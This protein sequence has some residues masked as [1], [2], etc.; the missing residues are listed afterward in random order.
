MTRLDWILLGFV[1][2]TAL[3]G[4]RS[5]LVATL[6]SLA[7]LVAGAVFGARVAPGL[8]SVD[9]RFAA[10]VALGGGVAGAV[11]LRALASLAGSFVRGGLRLV[12]PL[13]ALDSAG[14]AALGALWG[15]AL[16]W[17]AGAVAL[18]LPTQGKVRREVKTSQ[19]IQRL[20]ELAPPREVLDV[21]PRLS[22]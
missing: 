1:A 6:L 17:V 12:P 21:R 8:L 9:P 4:L 5:G 19:V 11:L 20:N 22:L 2:L 13:H 14:G 18:Q 15:L 3:A 7:G 10:L 16:V